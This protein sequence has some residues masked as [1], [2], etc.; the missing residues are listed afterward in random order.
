M[1]RSTCDSCC[2]ADKL[3]QAIKDDIAA[4]RKALDAQE[5]LD[6]RYANLPLLSPFRT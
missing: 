1:N 4:S 2:C 3:I 6:L 5:H